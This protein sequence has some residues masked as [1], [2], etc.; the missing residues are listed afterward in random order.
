M[1]SKN[2]KKKRI[3][4]LGDKER[5]SSKKRNSSKA[6]R[7]GRE[8]LKKEKKNTRIKRKTENME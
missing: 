2:Q 5:F 7:I 1:N 6:A 8:S 3:K 4:I